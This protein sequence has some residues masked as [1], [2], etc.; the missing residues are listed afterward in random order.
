MKEMH[1]HRAGSSKQDCSKRYP[2]NSWRMWVLVFTAGYIS[3]RLAGLAEYA[4]QFD[5]YGAEGVGSGNPVAFA[6][7]LP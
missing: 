1:L 4:P 3:L 7:N 6:S 2:H 5:S